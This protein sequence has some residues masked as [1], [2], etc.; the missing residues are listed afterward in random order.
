VSEEAPSWATLVGP[1]SVPD[2]VER[3]GEEGVV[4]SIAAEPGAPAAWVALDTGLDEEHPSATAPAKLFR[5]EGDGKIG[6]EVELPENARPLGPT[7]AAAHI[8]CP[9]QHDCWMV[10]SQGWL[11][12]L[13]VAGEALEPPPDSA[14][15]EEAGEGPIT[16]RPADESTIQ[17][18][19]DTL[20]EDDSGAKEGESTTEFA[21]IVAVPEEPFARVAVPLLSHVRSH[22]IGRTTLELS[23]HLAV[24]ARLQL[25]AKRHKRVV[26]KTP[27]K[28]FKAGNR[29]L[30]LRLNPR[31]WPTSLSLK[32]KPLAPLPTVS[33][34]ESSS[35]TDTV[36]AS[37][38]GRDPFA[39]TGWER[40]G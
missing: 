15:A 32:E 29:S 35:S 10:T 7:G 9:G 37:E 21:K 2:G 13:S 6:D 16:F 20:P 34:R 30:L 39:A 18:P 19:L 17:T 36:E 4:T 40:L 26:A 27:M 5:I 33:T 14:F 38:L 25:L 1:E 28:T 8:V 3:F 22:L 31:Q 23:F 11:F 24:K 12:Q